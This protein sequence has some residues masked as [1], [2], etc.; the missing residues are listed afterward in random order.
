MGS[1]ENRPRFTFVTA[2][3][4][5]M[6]LGLILG[7][8]SPPAAGAESR[9][10]ASILLTLTVQVATTRPGPPSVDRRPGCGW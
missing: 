6:L 2:R 8:G 9:G 1:A 5:A 10:G 7:F 4:T 3:L